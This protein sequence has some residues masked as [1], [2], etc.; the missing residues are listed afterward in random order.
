MPDG[1]LTRS[2]E[3]IIRPSVADQVFDSLYDRI[4]S[5]ELP[6]GA[7]ISEA[8]IAKALHVSRQPVRDAFY[9]L[10]KLRFLEI[11]PQRA[12][13]VSLI[14]TRALR[15][16]QFVRAALEAEIARAACA[17]LDEASLDHLQT[18]LAQ[19]KTAMD[20]D[21]R[22]R[23]HQLD[24]RFHQSICELSGHAFTWDTIRESKAHMDRARFLS[25][26][27]NAPQAYRDH[28]AILAALRARDPD[29][30][31]RVIR[32]HLGR[33]LDQIDR[34]RSENLDYFADEGA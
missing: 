12:T 33:I 2:L 27:F 32:D 34:I 29:R 5:L 24:D 30:A 18:L 26:S 13:T 4:L 20:S 9:R 31:D 15:E 11:R 25:L 14:S 28:L 21:D 8:D 6:P 19:Q 16:A 22:A 7:R 17:D 3:P 23:F 10:S 1:P